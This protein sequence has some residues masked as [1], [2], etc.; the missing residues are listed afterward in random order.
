MN[1]TPFVFDIETAGADE[2]FRRPD[3]VRLSG[4]ATPGSRATLT[5]DAG[6]VARL[7]ADPSFGPL[8]GHNITGSDLI[9]LARGHGLDL[10]LLRR[11]VDDADRTVRCAEPR[12][13]G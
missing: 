1:T 12:R 8:T 3:F 9:A 10:A 7:I 11:R 2:L 4:Y 5:T 6:E 13:A